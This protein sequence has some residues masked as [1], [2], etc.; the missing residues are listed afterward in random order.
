[1]VNLLPPSSLASKS[2]PAS[3]ISPPPLE[4]NF[5]GDSSS[6][7]FVLAR[8]R[9]SEMDNSSRLPFQPVLEDNQFLNEGEVEGGSSKGAKMDRETRGMIS[10]PLPNWC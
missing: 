2:V 4:K 5:E 8:S 7:S 6:A 9:T 1:M 3:D 10:I